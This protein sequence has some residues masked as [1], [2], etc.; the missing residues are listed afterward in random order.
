MGLIKKYKKILFDAEGTLI[1]DEQFL[2]TAALTL[3]EMVNKEVDVAWCEENVKSIRKL[4]FC[5]EKTV[6]NLKARGV[7]LNCELAYITYMIALI[8]RAKE[9]ADEDIY[10]FI[11]T[12]SEEIP[13]TA[14]ELFVYVINN[15][16]KL[17]DFDVAF[18][19]RRGTLWHRIYDVFN[20]WY[21]G[22]ELYEEVYKKAPEK[23]LSRN[24]FI[25]NEMPACEL[26]ELTKTLYTLK[27]NGISLGIVSGRESHEVTIPLTNWGLIEYFDEES[28]VTTTEVS[29]AEE[30]TDEKNI[31]FWGP[32]PFMY[33]K[34]VFGEAK[35]TEEIMD[36]EGELSECLA[37]VSNS[38]NVTAVRAAGMHFAAV[39]DGD[40]QAKENFEN[41]NA[42][43]IFKSVPEMILE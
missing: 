11:N 13:V 26:S 8:A 36:F 43:Y 28:I 29:A 17:Y 9:V 21:F 6:E 38:A 5:N 4:V 25:K 34:G 24:G 39:T 2:N 10:D 12:Y 19:K 42:D 3:F 35:T 33:L 41:L 31:G 23:A 20:E 14:P 27:D 15:V 16:M 22:D 37:V 1:S 40:L 7:N 18:L 32:H 30:E